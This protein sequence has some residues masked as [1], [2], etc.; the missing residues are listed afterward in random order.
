MKI[1][2]ANIVLR[3]LLNDVKE[4]ADKAA[5]IIENDDVLIPVE[6]IA[7]IVYVLEKVYKVGRDDILSSLSGL[8]NYENI[9]INEHE[10]VCS[11]LRN[12]ASINLDFVDCL[13]L[14]YYTER[15][16][17][18]DTFDEKLKKQ[19]ERYSRPE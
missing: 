8:I 14:S 9:I 7:E 18:V 13:L 12:Y 19:F 6:I 15:Q 4:L 10:V 11:A 17:Q 2:D 16:Y 5:L 1:V 3:Y